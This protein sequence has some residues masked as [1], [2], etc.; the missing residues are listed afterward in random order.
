MYR[1]NSYPLLSGVFSVCS[2]SKVFQGRKR[3][4]KRAC[5][6]SH[7]SA[8]FNLLCVLNLSE[9]VLLY[10]YMQGQVHQ[11]NSQ[12]HAG[13][14]PLGHCTVHQ[15]LY[16]QAQV[17]Q[18]TLHAGIGPL[19]HFTCRYRSTSPLYMQAQV[20][21]PTLHAGIGPLA[22]FTVACRHRSTSPLYMQ[23]QVHQPTLQ[24]HGCIGPLVH[25]TCRHSSTSPLYMQA[26]VHQTSQSELSYCFP[27]LETAF[28][29]AVCLHWV[30]AYHDL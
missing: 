1:S 28:F 27:L 10:S 26:Q 3:R 13:I 21:Q 30:L 14:G 22:H 4:R 20:H 6:E 29:C 15:P 5:L 2:L 12:L 8:L 19:A 9:D 16:M 7:I 18:L 17:H 23:A 24:L 11:P 25:F